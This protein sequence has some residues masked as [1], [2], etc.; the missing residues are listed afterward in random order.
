MEGLNLEKYL[1]QMKRTIL[2]SSLSADEIKHYLNEGSFKTTSYGK[3]NIVHFVGEICS[4]LEII[5]LGRVVVERI[6][7]S[8][9]LM[10]VAEFLSDDILGGNLL[11]SKNPY[12]PMTITSKQSTLILEIKKERLFQ[13]LSDNHDF[14]RGYLEYASN[15][16]T[17]LGDRIKHYVNKTIRESVMSFL[18]YERKKQNSNR[19][20]LNITKKA[21]AEKIGVQRTSLSRELAKMKKDGLI[22]YDTDSIT[23]LK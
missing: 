4:R 17:I 23:L 13:L 18:E 6:D 3:N 21:L 20:R 9:N 7:E 19:I 15:H 12:Y 8:G 5:L 11:F 1:E 22:L 14:L 10:T 16:A 2:L